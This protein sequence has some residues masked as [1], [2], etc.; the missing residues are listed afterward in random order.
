MGQRQL[1]PESTG[2]LTVTGL[3]TAANILLLCCD[4]RQGQSA[5]SIGAWLLEGCAM[6]KCHG[7]RPYASATVNRQQPAIDSI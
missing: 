5:H 6:R 4:N 3:Y 1:L 2:L 7:Q